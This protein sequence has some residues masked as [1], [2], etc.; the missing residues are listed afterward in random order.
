MRSLRSPGFSALLFL[1]LLAAASFS[2]EPPAEGLL[3]QLSGETPGDGFTADFARGDPEPAY[4]HEYSI[5]PDGFKGK[6]FSGPHSENKLMAYLAPGNIYAERGTV[7]FFW[8]SRD[9]V[10]KM[11]FK[12]FYVSACDQAS[13]DMTWMRVDYNGKGFEGFVTDANM[14][15]IRVA[16]NPPVFPAPNKWTHIA[17]AWDETQGVQLFMDGA[18]V[19]HKDTTG[20]FSCGLGLF[21][22][23]GRFASPGT[24]TSNCGHLRGGDIDEIA[25]YD[26]MLDADQVKRLAKGESAG[27]LEPLARALDNPR[28]RDEWLLRNGWNDPKHIPPYLSETCW[29]VRKVEIHDVYDQKKW[30]WRS[31]DGIRETSWPNIYNRSAL[32]GRSDYF[33]EPDWYCYST[34]G[35][36]ITYTLP[37]EPWNYCELAGAAFGTATRLFLDNERQKEREERLF[38]RPQGRERTF[39]LSGQSFFGGKI[40]FE[41]EVREIPLAEFQVYHV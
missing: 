36:S 10:G 5:I 25:I 19:A 29:A 40:R 17:L 33:I 32:L 11:P 26:R 30:V 27:N 22:P 18:L 4:L 35:K 1:F 28:Y 41:N 38:S 14:A 7:S 9:P 16:Y 8:R 6:A 15:R 2:A 39:H 23:H 13:L 20:I 31:N 12:I 21:N 37:H 24:V 3:F 34:S